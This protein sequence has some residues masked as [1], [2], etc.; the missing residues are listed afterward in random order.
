[1]KDNRNS[2]WRSRQV[3]GMAGHVNDYGSAQAARR[4]PSVFSIVGAP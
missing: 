3:E 2:I 4:D 1:M